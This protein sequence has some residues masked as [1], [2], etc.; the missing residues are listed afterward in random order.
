MTYISGFN[1]KKCKRYCP[2]KGR[3]KYSRVCKGKIYIVVNTESAELV[4]SKKFKFMASF[5]LS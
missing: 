1:S 3:E 5:S 4:H 2:Y